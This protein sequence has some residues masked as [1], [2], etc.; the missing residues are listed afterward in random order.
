MSFIRVRLYDL[1]A[2]ETR[3]I[4]V[5][6]EAPATSNSGYQNLLFVDTKYKDAVTRKVTG[7]STVS[8]GCDRVSA[9]VVVEPAE[10][11]EVTKVYIL[12]SQVGTN[13]LPSCSVAFINCLSY[14]AAVV[15]ALGLLFQN[16][17]KRRQLCSQ[18][19]YLENTRS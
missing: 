10:R 12:T 13:H 6:V 11:V 17:T 7:G 18:V 4:L 3:D 14:T 8:I 15:L 16:S 2:Q 9:P 19:P 5:T 1:F